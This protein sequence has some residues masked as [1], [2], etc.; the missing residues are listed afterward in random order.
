[1]NFKTISAVALVA[2]FAGNAFAESP[3]VLKDDFVSLKTRAEVQSELAQY[4]ADG[5]NP[6]SIQYNPLKSFKSTA[7]RAEVTAAYIAD[8]DE[9]AAITGEDS[10]STYFASTQPV[11]A[12]VNVAANGK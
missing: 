11:Q 8:R 4:K 1:M 5:V 2:A 7:S 12:G 3:T 6:W 9:V 10:G